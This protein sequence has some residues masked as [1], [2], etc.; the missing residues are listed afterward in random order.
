MIKRVLF[1]GEGTEESLARWEQALRKWAE[2]VRRGTLRVC[3]RA[4]VQV[5]TTTLRT[6][7]SYSDDCICGSCEEYRVAREKA[8]QP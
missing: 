4:Q 5:F 1:V 8:R 3:D 2:D 7:A 6:P